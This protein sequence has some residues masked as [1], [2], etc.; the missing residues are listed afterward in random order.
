[1]QR[2]VHALIAIAILAFIVG[3]PAYLAFGQGG[4]SQNVSVTVTATP[5]FV[6]GPGGGGGGGGETTVVP[7]LTGLVA[8]PALEPDPN[9]IVQSTCQ[10]KT[11]DGKLTLDIAKGTR[12]LDSSGK[13]LKSLSA[14]LKPSPPAPPSDAAIILAYELGPNGATFSPPITLEYTYESNDIPEGVAEERLVIAS[15]DEISGEWVKLDSIVDTEANTIMAKTS[16]LTLFAVFGYKVE[17]PPPAAFQISSLGISPTEVEIGKGVNLTIL[18]TNTG[19]QS[20]SYQVI[21]KINGVA[22]AAKE[23]ILDAGASEQV[24]FTTSKEAAGTYSVD[25]NGVTGAFEVKQKPVL[26]PAKPINW[27]LIGGIIGG[28]VVVVGLI[29]LVRRGSA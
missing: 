16:H 26:P 6:T 24:S 7:T 15:Y 1:M 3:F 9:G 22:E 4:G 19:G 29:Y 5:S 10:L 20:A 12:L 11:S 8:I 13:P 25:I 2:A 17:A 18:V 28:V 21:L 23:V 14:A 27:W